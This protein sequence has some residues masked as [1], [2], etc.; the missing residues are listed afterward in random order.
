MYTRT[1]LFLP[2]GFIKWPAIRSNNKNITIKKENFPM[3]Y[4]Q[5][6]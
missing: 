1:E 4:S 3:S 5:L 6:F 2:N